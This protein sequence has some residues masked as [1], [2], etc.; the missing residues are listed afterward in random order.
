MLT[1]AH[2][3]IVPSGYSYPSP[4]V[5]APTAASAAQPST[6]QHAASAYGRQS[7]RNPDSTP[8]DT[9][10]PHRSETKTLVARVAEQ[11]SSSRP[12]PSGTSRQDCSAG[13][14]DPFST[15]APVYLP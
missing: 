10:P 12:A 14:A 15:V 9:H 1:F 13:A 2:P 7:S 4:P 3:A 5:R 6:P 11:R 8:P